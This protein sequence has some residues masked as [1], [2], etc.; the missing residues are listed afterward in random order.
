ME[1]RI[2]F[3]RKHC[4]VLTTLPDETIWDSTEYWNEVLGNKSSNSSCF[5]QRKVQ[6]FLQPQQ[7]AICYG[8]WLSRQKKKIE[9]KENE[10]KE[11]TVTIINVFNYS[12]TVIFSDC[13]K[14]YWV[15]L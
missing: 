14:Y 11:K 4:K 7:Y 10:Q 13:A 5:G 6:V 2:A 1:S 12:V 9:T 15:F 8:D 3:K